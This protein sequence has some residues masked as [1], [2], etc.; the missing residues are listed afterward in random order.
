MRQPLSYYF[1]RTVKN[2]FEF[3]PS[4]SSGL[5]QSTHLKPPHPQSPSNE[6]ALG[7][8]SLWLYQGQC[9][10]IKWSQKPTN[11]QMFI[12]TLLKLYGLSPTHCHQSTC[13]NL[14]IFA[15][16]TCQ[17]QNIILILSKHGLRITRT[18]STTRKY[19]FL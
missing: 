10:L 17:N 14:T 15:T 19:G 18:S 16:Q 7:H 3:P 13:V 12:K 11:P 9:S 8:P 5:L 1:P 2:E 4:W 6:N